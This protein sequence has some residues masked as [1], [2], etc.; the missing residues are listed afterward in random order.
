[1]AQF[2]AAEEPGSRSGSPR[3]SA[4]AAR[5]MRHPIC[6]PTITPRTPMLDRRWSRR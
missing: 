4:R 5:P 3:R 2:T 1:V 6:L